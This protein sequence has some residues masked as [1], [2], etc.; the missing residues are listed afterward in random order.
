MIKIKIE[1]NLLGEA[2]GECCEEEFATIT[3]RCKSLCTNVRLSCQLPN[4]SNFFAGFAPDMFFQNEGG[5]RKSGENTSEKI[6]TTSLSSSIIS[7]FSVSLCII[8]EMS[9]LIQ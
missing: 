1:R 5:T 6:L 2:V 7:L 3:M 9:E 8:R 4:Q